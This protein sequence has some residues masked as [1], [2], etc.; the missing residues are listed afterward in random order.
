MSSSVFVSYRRDDA[1]SD[2]LLVSTA[3]RDRLGDEAV[4]MDTKSLTGGEQWPDVL[5]DAVSVAE[6]V[7]AVIGP[8]WVRIADQWGKRRID[9]EDDWVRLELA[10]ALS[11]PNKRV[12][13]VLV[14]GARLPPADAL[15]AQIQPLL[16]R[17][18][19]EIRRDYFNHDIQ[20]L[21]AQLGDLQ[22]STSGDTIRSSPYPFDPPEGPEA[23]TPTRLQRMLETELSQ[24]RLVDSALPEDPT[25]T[26]VE[27]HREFRFK[28][29]Q[30]AIAFM[31]QVAP[32]CDIAIHHPRWENIWKT[33]RV[34]LTTW[35][36]GHQVS[37]R[38][39]QLARYFD[40][41][42]SEFDGRVKPKQVVK[43][44]VHPTKH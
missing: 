9:Q 18:S 22:S 26:R 17:Q 38:D 35:D 30:A 7:I 13:P 5:R 28:S 37:D 2:A 6:V 19:I 43:A 34:Y 39:V 36:I 3:I 31:M 15:P 29:F 41:A 42:Y 11:T 10:T 1:A 16:T 14:R 32:G 23:I 25:I 21:I 24:W 40:R 27:L 8:D 33:L 44:T 12:I 4:F 20:L